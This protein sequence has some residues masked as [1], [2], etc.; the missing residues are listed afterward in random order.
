VLDLWEEKMTEQDKFPM[1]LTDEEQA[2]LRGAHGETLRKAMAS[3][4]AYGVAFEAERLLP[5]DGA[6]HMVTSFGANI[7]RPYFAMIDDLIA[8]GLRT[9]RPFTVD[10]RPVDEQN[11]PYSFLEKLALKL[12]YGK[13]SSYEQQ[14]AQLGLR[15]KRAFSC[16]CYLPQVGNIPQKGAILSWSESSA[17]IFA[18]SVLGARTNRNS[19]GIDLLCNLVGKAPLFGLLTDQGRRATW[20]VDV[21]TSVL[22]N[23]QLLGSAIGMRVVEDVPYI[24]GLDRFLGQGLAP[25]AISYLKDMGAA[26]ASNGAVGLYHV[27]NCTPEAVESGRDLL[28]E[29]YQHYVIDDAE[30]ERVMQGYPVLWKRLDARPE[31]CFIGCPHL[32]LEQIRWWAS[33]VYEALQELGQDRVKVETVLCAAPEVVEQFKQDRDLFERASAAGLRFT[34]ICPLMY[35]NNPLSARRAVITNSNKLRTYSTA[36]F[37]LDQQVLDIIVRG[38]V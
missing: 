31:R 12:I 6:P 38:R 15:D 36:R 16:T 18:N 8:A 35:M 22:P 29:G 33:H 10:P 14:L 17:V 5:I 23:A 27:E 9:D 30:L 25:A 4:V 32:S 2:I 28:V 37:F 13:Q 11:V 3:V 24:I 26:A 19:A 1:A 20:L 7:I 34:S 21:Q